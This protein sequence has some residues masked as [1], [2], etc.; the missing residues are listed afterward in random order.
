MRSTADTA[1]FSRPAHLGGVETVSVAY[2]NRAFPVHAHGEYV[3]GTILSGCENLTVGRAG[4]RVVKDDI[5]RLHPEEAHANHSVGPDTLRYIVFY[6]PPASIVPFL[7]GEAGRSE[8]SF[9][10]ATARDPAFAQ[11]LIRAH[12]TLGV[13]ASGRLEQES[14]LMAVVT[15]LAEN[16]SGVTRPSGDGG[17]A[18]RRARAWIEAHFREN[19]GLGEVAA[20]AGLSLFR[21]GHL[22]KDAV[23]LSPIAYR[24]QRRVT[25]ARRLLLAGW[26]I[27]DAALEMGFADQS[28]LTRQFQRIVGTSPRRYLRQ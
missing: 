21:L 13:A 12:R 14:A 22:F 19:F 20:A 24:N 16:G 26:S 2:R 9:S 28:H 1:H 17:I 7:D 15:G 6:L 8:L 3:V 23:G 4:H 5:L 10:R 25:E 27:A 11:T 18:I